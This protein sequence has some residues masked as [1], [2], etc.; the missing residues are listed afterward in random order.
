MRIISCVIILE[1]N[2]YLVQ[3]DD[4]ISHWSLLHCH[5]KNSN[6]HYILYIISQIDFNLRENMSLW[7]KV[8]F[9]LSVKLLSE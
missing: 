4:H 2:E 3:K 8:Y 7:L 1:T 6:R 5:W 9:R